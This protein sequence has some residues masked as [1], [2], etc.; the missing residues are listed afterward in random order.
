MAVRPNGEQILRGVERSLLTHVLP[1]LS[2]PYAQAQVRYAAL[3][4]NLLAAEWDDAAQR[5]LDDNAALR[6]WCG[7]AANAL[8]HAQ[9]G[10]ADTLRAAAR[11]Q[12][13]DIRLSTLSAA[14]DRL[15]ALTTRALRALTANG[16]AAD[17]LLQ[18]LRHALRRSVQRRLA[19]SLRP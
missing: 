10:L 16:G 17:D 2:S 9:P 4:L 11:E 8:A 5:L 6:A 18:E 19:G 12:E 13:P 15:R 1:E 3:L 7:R 14:N